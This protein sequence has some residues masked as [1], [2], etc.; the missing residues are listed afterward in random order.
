MTPSEL[1]PHAGAMVMLDRVIA[2]DAAGALCAATSHLNLTNPL[3]HGQILPAI[4][5]AEFVLQ[6]AAVHGALRNG[7]KR[8][9]YVAVLR[10]VILM[11][12]RLDDPTLGELHADA[13]LVDEM[14]DGVV[15]DLHLT[16]EAGDTLLTGRAIIAW[17]RNP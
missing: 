9:G 17:P 12:E 4:C 5:G 8:R 2:W 1:L 3:R 16:S 15:Y 11:V 13:R 10:D 14:Q 7:E 6:A